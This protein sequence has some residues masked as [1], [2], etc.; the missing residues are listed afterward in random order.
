M[1]EASGEPAANK[2]EEMETAVWQGRNR[3]LEDGLQR[4]ITSCSRGPAGGALERAGAEGSALPMGK[5]LWS[6]AR[7][8]QGH[9]GVEE[10][11]GSDTVD[12]VPNASWRP[13]W[14]TEV[15]PSL[16][17]NVYGARNDLDQLAEVGSASTR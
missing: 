5:H 14:T 11:I 3:Q 17:E 8:L 7:S 16:E 4:A 6:R 1:I 13:S 10:L 12:T 2:R 15:R 9:D